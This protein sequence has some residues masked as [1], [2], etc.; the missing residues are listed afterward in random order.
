MLLQNLLHVAR[1]P[2]IFPIILSPIDFDPTLSSNNP[3]LADNFG[4]PMD[5]LFERAFVCHC[6]KQKR[7]K[8]N[9][10]MLFTMNES[11]QIAK[12]NKR[13]RI[14]CGTISIQEL[15]V[16]NWLFSSFFFRFYAR[17]TYIMLL[18]C[19]N[20]SLDCLIVLRWNVNLY[21][22]RL[23]RAKWRIVAFMRVEWVKSF[24]MRSYTH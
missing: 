20:R 24:F 4:Q 15:L 12:K 10:F 18:F 1:F 11:K 9:K 6:D 17:A 22:Y 2:M 16:K 21:T 19:R 8:K 13:M 5:S 23:Y 3:I 14:G 7:K